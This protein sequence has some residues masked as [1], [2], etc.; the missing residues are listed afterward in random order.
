VSASAIAYDGYAAPDALTESGIAAVVSDFVQAAIR[1]IEAG[2]DVLEIHAAHGYLLHQFLS[3]LS[4]T[5]EDTFGGSLENRARLLLSIVSEIR[6]AVGA[7]VPLFVRL[8]A[9]DWAEGGWDREETAVVSRW[10]QEAGADLVDISTGGNIGGVTIPVGPGYQVPFAEFVKR[11]SGVPT[12]AV[13]LITEAAQAEEIIASG[14]ADAVMFA[15]E[16]L[17][18]PH[19]ALR[20]A[21]ELG[22]ELDYWPGQYERARWA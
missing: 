17:R 12:S 9:T 21:H 15:R 6:T 14:R 11:E 3:P 5:R 19:F 4:N 2:F 13:G 22:V 20:A 18:D 10:A 7:D 8:S 1:A 16:I